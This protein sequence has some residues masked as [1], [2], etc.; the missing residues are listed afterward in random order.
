[1]P[2]TDSEVIVLSPYGVDPQTQSPYPP[3][4]TQ[5]KIR[6]WVQAV[7]DGRQ[8]CAG[9]PVL[10]VQHGVDAGG[11]RGVLT[12]VVECLLELPGLRVLIGRKDFNDL[13]LSV[14]E[15]FFEIVPSAVLAES[16]SQEHRYVIQ[17]EAGTSTVFFRELKDVKGLGSQ[18]FAIITV[19]EA[20]EIDLVAYRILKQR[21][22][23]AG[24]PLMVLLE[25]NP[26]SSE[27]HW[28]NAL[29]DPSHADYDPDLTRII[30]PS[31]E[32]W[33]YMTP[34]YRQSL[35]QMPPS[36]KKRYLLGETVAL[37]SGSPVYPACVEA[38]HLRPTSIVPDRSIIRGW[39]FGWR[40]AACVWA[41]LKDNT[42]ILFH[43][44]W[45]ALE[46][47]EDRFI[48]GVKVRTNAWFGARACADYGD[49]A[50]RNR[51]PHGVSTLQR[52]NQAGIGLRYRQTTYAQR[53]PLI[54]Q[55]FSLMLGEEPAIVIDPVGCPILA[56][57][58]LGG[59]HYPEIDPDKA[60]TNR[61]EVPMRDGWFEHLCNALEYVLVNLY[62]NVP[63]ASVQALH[64]RI[65]QRQ[66][67]FAMRQGAAV[68]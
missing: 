22:R 50:A 65:R 2:P 52:L 19:H 48:D 68:F 11:T 46:T 61:Q 45:M 62:G 63:T 17:G 64:R 38:I 1:M 12:P 32:N 21:C 24:Y 56:E 28:L 58:L 47:P 8:R 67:R 49:P 9:I 59:Y 43:R 16:D 25:G 29:A 35:E 42:Q 4:P 40:R 30:M 15:T 36:W 26:P 39:D 6:E 18:E 10:Y 27:A 5:Q 51:D 7:R 31:Y 44:E 37:P 13:R 66:R 20:H 57:G 33:D 54:N 60:F 3:H 34:S 14:M 41:Q 23:Q 53:I 55:R